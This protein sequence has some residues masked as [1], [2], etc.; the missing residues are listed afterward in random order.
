M[1]IGEIDVTKD[2]D[3]NYPLPPNMFKMLEFMEI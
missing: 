2:N 1:Y 3:L